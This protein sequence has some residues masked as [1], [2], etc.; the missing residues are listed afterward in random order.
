[1]LDGTCV[2]PQVAD[3]V[4]CVRAQGARLSQEQAKKLSAEAGYAGATAKLASDVGEKLERQYSASDANTL[5]V[6]K[7]C[8]RFQEGGAAP[9]VGELSAAT[10]RPPKRGTY[11]FEDIA[12]QLAGLGNIVAKSDFSENAPKPLIA[13]QGDYWNALY[14]DGRFVLKVTP[15]A[16]RWQ[17][18]NLTRPPDEFVAYVEVNVLASLPGSAAFFAWCSSDIAQFC[19]KAILSVDGAV[20]LEQRDARKETPE[21]RRLLGKTQSATVKFNPNAVAALTV[22]HKGPRVDVWIDGEPA[23]SA[24]VPARPMGFLS[25]GALNG[26]TVAFDN[27]VVAGLP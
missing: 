9:K 1:M 23:L 17:G 15:N 14:A 12:G 11:T 21:D 19:T 27:V 6:I 10:W 18:L 13:G 4:G 26:A 20:R 16:E 3:Y 25:L 24:D 22:R 5:A 2:S 7:A 8:A